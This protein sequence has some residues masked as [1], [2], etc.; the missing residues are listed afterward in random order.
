MFLRVY[1]SI[2]YYLL[3]EERNIYKSEMILCWVG[4][5][6]VLGIGIEERSRNSMLSLK[7]KKMYFSV[8]F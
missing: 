2:V 6:Q 7:T 8:D 5:G 3:E 1:E 4:H